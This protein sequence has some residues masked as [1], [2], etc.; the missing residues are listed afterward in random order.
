MKHLIILLCA[1][2]I[3]LTAC[4]SSP[5]TPVVIV[6]KVA[7]QRTTAWVLVDWKTSS[8]SQAV[9]PGPRKKPITLNFYTIDT[10]QGT[11]EGT[12]RGYTGCNKVEGFYTETADTLNIG[13]LTMTKQVCDPLTMKME[14]AF[15]QRISLPLQKHFTHSNKG[16]ILVLTSTIGEKLTFMEAGSA[17]A[18]EHKNRLSE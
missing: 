14:Q 15:I 9:I 12:V 4:V 11:T 17:H 6:N 3:G 7:P 8:G 13:K 10:V 16:K 18:F 2:L 1:S 5:Q